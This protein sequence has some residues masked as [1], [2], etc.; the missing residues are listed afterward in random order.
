MNTN[1][2]TDKSFKNLATF[3]NEVLVECPHCKKK[4]VIIPTLGHHTV[5]YPIEFKANFKCNNCYKPINEKLWYGPSIILPKYATCSYCG[6]KLTSNLKVNKYQNT[7]K[8]KCANCKQENQKA[9]SYKLTYA[10]SK[11][12]IDPYFGLQ[13]WL[14]A[15]FDSNILWAY[16]LDHLEYLKN[17]VGAKLREAA[18]GGKY[19]LAWKLPNFIKAAKNRDA[20]L[21]AITRLESK[22]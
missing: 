10:D 19:A 1:P 18:S 6:N 14:Q 11:Q 17:Y 9:V 4:A 12:A 16:N 3:A 20:I 5:P 2:R 7:I 22:K 21:K 8:V 15:P 13:L